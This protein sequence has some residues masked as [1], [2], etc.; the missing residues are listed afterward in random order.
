MADTAET[1]LSKHVLTLPEAIRKFTSLAAQRMGLTERG[2]IKVGMYADVVVFDPAK[3]RDLATFE[4][5][6]QLAEGMDYVIV[7]GVPVLADG[8]MTHALPGK[9]LRGPGYAPAK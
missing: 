1:N 9:V 2:V 6:N 3:V 4:Q 5:P 7:N 8:K